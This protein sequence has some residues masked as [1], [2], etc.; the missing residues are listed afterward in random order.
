MNS[1][2]SDE[3]AGD[4]NESIG[5]RAVPYAASGTKHQMRWM[6]H[7]VTAPAS[8]AWNAQ[9]QAGTRQPMLVWGNQYRERKIRHTRCGRRRGSHLLEHSLNWAICLYFL[10][11]VA[12]LK[13]TSTVLDFAI[14]AR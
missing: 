4:D 9:S 11:A 2:A 14:A 5:A 1:H 10:S 12:L 8:D 6:N 7:L 13:N 3:A